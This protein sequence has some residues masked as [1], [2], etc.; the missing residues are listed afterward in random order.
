MMTMQNPQILPKQLPIAMNRP[1]ANQFPTMIPKFNLPNDPKILKYWAQYAKMH[2]MN[3]QGQV[4]VQ[5]P[6]DDKREG[7]NKG[8]NRDSYRKKRK[9]DSKHDR[10]TNN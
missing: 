4:M 2:K 7:K 1:M 5:L 10:K 9:R 3:P 8:S 6:D